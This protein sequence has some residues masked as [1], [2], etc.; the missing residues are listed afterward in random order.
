MSTGSLF[1]LSHLPLVKLWT[2]GLALYG[3][4]AN[5]NLNLVH[6]HFKSYGHRYGAYRES[7]QGPLLFC[8]TRSPILLRASTQCSPEMLN[9]SQL[10]LPYSESVFLDTSCSLSTLSIIKAN[11]TLNPPYE[12]PFFGVLKPP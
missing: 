8:G 1:I 9:S 10:L 7:A 11:Q 4:T 6:D 3:S 5:F 2:F 12:I